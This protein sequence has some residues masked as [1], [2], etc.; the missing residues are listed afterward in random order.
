MGRGFLVVWF[1]GGFRVGFFFGVLSP[2]VGGSDVLFILC[3]D[4]D[5]FC[6]FD[7]PNWFK[8]LN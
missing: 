2:G 1:L 6:V 5:T 4:E 7:I 8:Y 3:E